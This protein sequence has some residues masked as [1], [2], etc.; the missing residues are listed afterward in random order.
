MIANYPDMILRIILNYTQS[1]EAN[2]H[3][4]V[5][6]E[7]EVEPDESLAAMLTKLQ[8]PKCTPCMNQGRPNSLY[9]FRT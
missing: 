8:D 2:G 5:G 7:F 3:S 9:F 4:P 1:V 6:S